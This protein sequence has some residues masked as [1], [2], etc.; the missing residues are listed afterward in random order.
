MQEAVRGN[1]WRRTDALLLEGYPFGGTANFR[2]LQEA[3]FFTPQY[4]YASFTSGVYLGNLF[5]LGVLMQCGE[6]E[7]ESS[8]RFAL[9]YGGEVALRTTVGQL[10]LGMS[11]FYPIGAWQGEQDWL[12][13]LQLRF[14]F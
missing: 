2:G 5:R 3:S 13:H 4:V 1:L 14:T 10:L 11:R 12:L 7:Y 8:I 9:S 6:L